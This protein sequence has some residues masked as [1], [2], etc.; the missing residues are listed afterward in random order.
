MK[1][2]VERSGQDPAVVITTYEGQHCHHSIGFVPVLPQDAALF[3]PNMPGSLYYPTLPFPQ[4]NIAGYGNH[5]PGRDGESRRLPDTSE[6]PLGQGLLG[7]IVPPLMRN[8]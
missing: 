2:R 1:K 3:P 5:A 4:Q 8:P 6:V 7:D